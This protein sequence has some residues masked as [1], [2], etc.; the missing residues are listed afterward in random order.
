MTGGIWAWNLIG[1]C[2]FLTPWAAKD[3]AA[4]LAGLHDGLTHR[5]RC[6]I[7]R[8]P[9][10]VV[11]PG[12]QRHRVNGGRGVQRS[13]KYLFGRTQG[14]PRKSIY[15]CE[16]AARLASARGLDNGGA[17]LGALTSFLAPWLAL[18]CGRRRGKS[19]NSL[20]RW[21]GTTS[22]NLALSRDGFCR[23]ARTNLRRRAT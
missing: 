16:G 4:P 11:R 18:V 6:R 8:Q 20:I 23:P 12:P 9:V 22:E 10:I 5:S 17:A 13:T 3:A 1:S 21:N 15:V 7:V 14:I 19:D 2:D